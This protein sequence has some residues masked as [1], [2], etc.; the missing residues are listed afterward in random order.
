LEAGIPEESTSRR[1]PLIWVAVFIVIGCALGFWWFRHRP[2]PAPITNFQ[3][4]VD[5]GYPVTESYPETCTVS[6][7]LTFT[8]GTR[9]AG[10]SEPKSNLMYDTLVISQNGPPA[11]SRVVVRNQAEWVAFWNKAHALIQPFPPLLPV[12]FTKD[13]VVAVMLGQQ[14]TIGYRLKIDN[15]YEVPREVI[16]EAQATKP[17]AGC[18]LPTQ[19]SAPYHIV[20]F[21]KSAKPIVFDVITKDDTSVC[22]PRTGQPTSGDGVLHK[23]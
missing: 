5:A 14:S 23:Y 16:V 12:D 19:L 9:Q 17:A 2:K 13:M 11:S 7:G 21:P 20:K 8:D 22:T 6:R 10:A 3:Q 1:R 15:V 4:C 18:S